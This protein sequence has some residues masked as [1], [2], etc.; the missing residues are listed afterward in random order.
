LATGNRT[1]DT[2]KRL[3]LNFLLTKTKVMAETVKE[4]YLG[5]VA[6]DS[7]QLMICDPCY[8]DSE[9]QNEDFVDIRV[10]EH[11]MTKE[12][13]TYGKDFANYEEVIPKYGKTMNQLNETGEW[14]DVERPDS[15]HGFSYNACA[16]ATLSAKGHGELTFKM[17]HTGAGLAFSTA[18]GDGIYDVYG[19]YDEDGVIKAVVVYL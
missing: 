16:N 3:D 10:H 6:V 11:K 1:G 9:W 17:G 18:Y 2:G 7:G 13:L 4:V 15:K 8:I 5:S 19:H 12:R 14:I